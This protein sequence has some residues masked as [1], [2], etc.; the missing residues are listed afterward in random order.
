MSNAGF[1]LIAVAGIVA[2]SLAV[3]ALNR[4]PKTFMSS[5]DDFSREM[6]ALGRD[7]DEP[8][9][10]RRRKRPTQPPSHRSSR[11]P[12]TGINGPGSRREIINGPAGPPAPVDPEERR[13]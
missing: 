9:P 1:L 4:K 7:S 6:K 3:W 10:T 12:G 2:G 5:I 11:S 13:P 8:H